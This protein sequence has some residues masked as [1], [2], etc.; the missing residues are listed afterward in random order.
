M[1]TVPLGQ[2]NKT[3]QPFGLSFIGTVFAHYERI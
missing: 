1:A 3:G 2:L